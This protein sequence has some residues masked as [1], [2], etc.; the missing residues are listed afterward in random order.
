MNHLSHLLNLWHEQRDAHRWVLGTVYRTQGPAYRKAGAMMLFNDLG[1][2][3]GLLS[4]GCL[5]TELHQQ[6]ARV[7]QS[8]KAVTL[9]YDGS[10]ED[11]LSFQLGIGCGGTVHILLQAITPENNYLGLISVHERLKQHQF[12]EFWQRIPDQGETETKVIRQYR[13]P[14]CKQS[15]LQTINAQTWL[16]SSIR[17]VEHLL[18]AGGGTDAR[19]LVALASQLGW[20]VTL[21]DSRPANARRDYFPSAANILRCN[22]LDLPDQNGLKHC[23]AAVVMTHNLQMDAD[24]LS[25]L[26]H[27]P[28]LRY[29]ALLGPQTRKQQVLSLAGLSESQVKTPIA[30]PAGL[31]LGG[32]LPESIA[33]SILAEC[34]AVLHQADAVSISG[35]CAGEN[36]A[37]CHLA[38]RAL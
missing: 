29:L 33:L 27:L 23:D 13:A 22:A 8:Q 38:S 1:Q 21:W 14:Y 10:D 32:E 15:R 4:G 9:C 19:P 5:E 11:D 3:Y 28:A 17:P 7:T 12:S 35:L 37:S 26:Q 18:V 20:E 36:S 6:A 34:H 25:A 30:G 16:V 31:A 2:Q 24:A